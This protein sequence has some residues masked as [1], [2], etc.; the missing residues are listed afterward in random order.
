MNPTLR[1]KILRNKTAY[2]SGRRTVDALIALEVIASL[3]VPLILWRMTPEGQ[4]ELLTVLASVAVMLN[5]LLANAVRELLQAAFDAADASL[6][7]D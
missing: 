5:A 3:I 2:A 4:T 7:T 6:D 1:R